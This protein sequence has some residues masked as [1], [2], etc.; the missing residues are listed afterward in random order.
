MDLGLPRENLVVTLFGFNVGV[1]IGQLCV[2]VAFVPLAFAA[3][4]TLAYRKGALQFGSVA[5]AAVATVWLVQRI[6]SR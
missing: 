1:E 2:V 6:T 5:I 3:R 4:K